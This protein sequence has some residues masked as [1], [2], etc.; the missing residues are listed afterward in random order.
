MWPGVVDDEPPFSFKETLMPWLGRISSDRPPRLGA[1]D[2]I[3][4]TSRPGTRHAL[5]SSDIL[6]CQLR[7]PTR[8]FL[9]LFGMREARDGGRE[10]APS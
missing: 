5:H 2:L 6:E 8:I 4:A 9:T 10:S 1:L 3:T 7:Y